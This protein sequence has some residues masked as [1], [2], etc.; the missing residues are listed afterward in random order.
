MIRRLRAAL[1]RWLTAER[2]AVDHDSVRA[3]RDATH[4]GMCDIGQGF[5]RS[6]LERVLDNERYLESFQDRARPNSDTTY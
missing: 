2:S 5:G 3:Y 1:H 4:L 6:N